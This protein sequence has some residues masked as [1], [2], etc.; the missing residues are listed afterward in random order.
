MLDL[1]DL[2]AIIYES[3][4]DLLGFSIITYD[5]TE[6]KISTLNFRGERHELSNRGR[7]TE[8][9]IQIRDVSYVRF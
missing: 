5:L 4:A 3:I 7:G 1:S 8:A 6:T 2:V 9:F